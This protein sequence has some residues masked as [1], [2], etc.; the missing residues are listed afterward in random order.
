MTAIE[1]D[2][3]IVTLVNAAAEENRRKNEVFLALIH[4]IEGRLKRLERKLR[5]AKRKP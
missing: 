1:R 5:K 3:L 4:A 2:E